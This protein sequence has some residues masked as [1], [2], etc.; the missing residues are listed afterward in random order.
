MRIRHP[1]V[2]GLEFFR[3]A[4]PAAAAVPDKATGKE[5]NQVQ[6]EQILAG[7]LLDPARLKRLLETDP[8]ITPILKEAT[9]RLKGG[10]DLMGIKPATPQST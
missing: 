1:A 5:T 3:T 8:G 10:A 7:T 2:P 4:A 9:T 6:D